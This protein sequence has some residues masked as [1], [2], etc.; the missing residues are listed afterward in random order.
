MIDWI[1]NCQIIRMKSC[2]VT[3][4][5][6]TISSSVL[7]KCNEW[8]YLELRCRLSLPSIHRCK[9]HW[10]SHWS[11]HWGGFEEPLVNDRLEQAVCRLE[12]H[13]CEYTNKV[14]WDWSD[15]WV[16]CQIERRLFLD[17][18]IRS[19]ISNRRNRR[20]SKIFNQHLPRI[21]HEF[22]LLGSFSRSSTLS[23]QL[24]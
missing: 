22:G 24:I 19:V 13:S 7:S 15:F 4:V 23:A 18:E 8:V 1:R 12:F 11:D 3:S 9:M 20:M 21:Q 6:A 17:E 5:G 2:K 10:C 14:Q 16:G